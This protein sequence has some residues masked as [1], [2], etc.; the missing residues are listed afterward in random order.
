MIQTCKSVIS[1]YLIALIEFFPD[2][3]YIDGLWEFKK[4][5]EVEIRGCQIFKNPMCGWQIESPKLSD[6]KNTAMLWVD[7]FI[8]ECF[9]EEFKTDS[10]DFESV[11]KRFHRE[12]KN[13]DSAL[14]W[15]VREMQ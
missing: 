13:F 1:V 3:E 12:V 5:Y 7:E 15:I 8:R 4:D 6:S 11:S 14:S 2:C 10:E 9:E